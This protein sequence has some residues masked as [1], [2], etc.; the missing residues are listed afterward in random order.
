MSLLWTTIQGEPT[1]KEAFNKTTNINIWAVWAVFLFRSSPKWAHPHVDSL[2]VYWTPELVST[3][4]RCTHPAVW[5]LLT[6]T[7]WS[8]EPRQVGD[9]WIGF[10]GGCFFHCFLGVASWFEREKHH[11]EVQKA[12]SLTC[13]KL[14]VLF[15]SHLFWHHIYH[16]AVTK[17]IGIKCEIRSRYGTF[18]LLPIT[19]FANF[20][21]IFNKWIPLAMHWWFQTLSAN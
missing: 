11:Q 16:F 9:T 15:V 3:F 10:W 19:N 2:N 18:Y 1:K 14:A 21:N 4:G 8:L 5:H 13:T 20:S 6:D 17:L 7:L 12:Q